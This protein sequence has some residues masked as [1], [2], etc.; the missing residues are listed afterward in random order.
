ARMSV[1]TAA[2]I[3]QRMFAGEDLLR[4]PAPDARLERHRSLA[5]EVEWSLS[6]LDPSCA[7]LFARMATFAGAASVGDLEPVSGEH[8]SQVLDALDG[9]VRFAMVQRR[10]D[11]DGTVRFIMPE[12]LRQLAVR[13]LDRDPD[14]ERWST[15]GEAREYLGGMDGAVAD[16]ATATGLERAAPAGG[17]GSLLDEAEALAQ[18]GRSEE[19]FQRLDEFVALEA[20]NP[21]RPSR[22]ARHV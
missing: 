22:F 14:A 2:Q 16:C 3:R 20:Q 19:A 13:A 17:G 5:A 8:A 9:L 21:E 4:R 18:A 15:R 1:L 11:G 7:T 10:E 12:A 6:L